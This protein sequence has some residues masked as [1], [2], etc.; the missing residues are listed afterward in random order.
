MSK[1]DI[2]L[3]KAAEMQRVIEENGATVEAF[4]VSQS[5]SSESAGIFGMVEDTE[6]VYMY[7]IKFDGEDNDSDPF[8]GLDGAVELEFES[9][10]E[11]EF[12]K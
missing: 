7:A 8:D 2:Q 10:E 3:D 5:H 6:T 9:Q 11:P 1:G 4:D 12:D